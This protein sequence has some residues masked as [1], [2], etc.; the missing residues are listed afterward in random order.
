MTLTSEEEAQF[1]T[2]SLPT[3]NA[4]AHALLAAKQIIVLM[5]AYRSTTHALQPCLVICRCMLDGK[6][7]HNVHL[8]D[9]VQQDCRTQS[10]APCDAAMRSVG[11]QVH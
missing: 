9:N 10:A 2:V 1:T 11:L 4:C 8:R 7:S 6:A 5:H 3:A